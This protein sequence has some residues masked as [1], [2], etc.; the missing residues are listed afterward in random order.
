[1]AVK[2]AALL[3]AVLLPAPQALQ[4]GEKVVAIFSGQL[5]S[6]LVGEAEF[7]AERPYVS[8]RLYAAT[9]SRCP[10][11]RIQAAWRLPASDTA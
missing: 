5:A 2:E 7:G 1:M 4:V 6:A 11:T 8:R 3:L 9:G 10:D